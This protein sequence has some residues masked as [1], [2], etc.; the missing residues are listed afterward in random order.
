VWIKHVGL[1]LVVAKRGR[2]SN[3]PEKSLPGVGGRYG[4]RDSVA[5]SVTGTDTYFGGR[6]GGGYT[7]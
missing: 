7:P 1:S 2:V 3:L 5:V 4:F 6:R